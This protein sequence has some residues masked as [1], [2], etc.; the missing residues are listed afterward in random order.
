[1]IKNKIDL[2]NYLIADNSCTDRK[3]I[4]SIIRS[5]IIPDYS[6]N[7]I[8]QKYKKALRHT[9]YALNTHNYFLLFYWGRI[10]RKTSRLTGFQIPLNTIGP[11]LKLFHWGTIIINARVRIGCNLTIHPNVIIGQ[12]IA[13]GGCPVIGDN[14]YICSGSIILGGITIGDN[15]KIAHNTI[16]RKNVPSNSVVAGYPARI[17]KLNGERVDLPL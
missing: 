15:V 1:M 12:K 5:I 7:N 16:I 14:C 8:L 6:G 9:E 13:G 3:N 4:I 10:L 17:I 11:G 2:N